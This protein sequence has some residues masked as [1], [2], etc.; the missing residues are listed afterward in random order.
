MSSIFD[1]TK[2]TDLM[3]YA[4]RMR[5]LSPFLD[6]KEIFLNAKK[7]LKIYQ[8][9]KKI[10]NP[11]SI[12]EARWYESLEKDSPDYSVYENK[13]FISNV[14][15]CWILYSRK[16]LLQVQK[17]ALYESIK[18]RVRGVADLGCGFGYT[19]AALKEMFP[20]ARCVGTN[21][22]DSL[23]FKFAER[24]TLER[25]FEVT[26][27]LKRIQHSDIVFASE[28][29]EHIERP[30]EH[31]REVVTIANPKILIIANAFNTR[32][33]GHFISYRDGN[34]IIPGEKIG[35]AFNGELRRLGY[36]TIKCG[37]W[38]NR[39]MVWAK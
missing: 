4:V 39:P 30:M 15:A 3:E 13:L 7:L 10:D 27:D 35:R 25:K 8:G 29:F 28:Y 32:A 6:E 34:E 12:L 5:A 16:Y 2:D 26:S 24:I 20:G 19:T 1:K 11:E 31:L 14:W 9:D 21:F 33:T 22:K 38:N 18:G 23:Q 17:S 37:F 36:K